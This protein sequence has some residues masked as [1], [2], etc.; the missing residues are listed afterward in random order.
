MLKR[1]SPISRAGGRGTQRL[2]DMSNDNQPPMAA[3]RQRRLDDLFED[4]PWLSPTMKA[5]RLLD[6]PRL[7]SDGTEQTTPVAAPVTRRSAL[8]DLVPEV[9]D[10]EAAM[11]WQQRIDRVPA[12]AFSEPEPEIS[13]QSLPFRAPTR[14]KIVD[15]GAEV[16]RSAQETVDSEAGPLWPKTH[17]SEFGFIPMAKAAAVLRSFSAYDVAVPNAEPVQRFRTDV[18]LRW[19]KHV[20]EREIQNI[21]GEG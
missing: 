16:T 2:P 12:E 10:A 8:M 3:T 7:P 6:A 9:S 1:L 13:T 15:T 5:R 17:T 11:F 4:E 18:L 19:L 21:P 20:P 14:L